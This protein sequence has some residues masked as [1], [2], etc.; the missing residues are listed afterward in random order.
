MICKDKR[1]PGITWL[2]RAMP[3]AMQHTHPLTSGVMGHMTVAWLSHNYL[4]HWLCSGTTHLRGD[5]IWG[6]TKRSSGSARDDVLPAHAEVGNLAV[7]FGVQQDIVEL[8]ISG[9]KKYSNT[10]WNSWP[11]AN[12]RP[13]NLSRKCLK[14]LVYAN[15]VEPP[16][17]GCTHASRTERCH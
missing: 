13:F 14:G 4:C 2:S 5:V 6:P 11:L 8:Q 10:W 7:S 9:R 17:N 15:T 12:F 3:L 1:T 16:H